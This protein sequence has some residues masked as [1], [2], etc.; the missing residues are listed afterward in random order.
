MPEQGLGGRLVSTQEQFLKL[1]IEA[2]KTAL[3]RIKAW[4]KC[5]SVDRNVRRFF[6]DRFNEM[7]ETP[8][9]TRNRAQIP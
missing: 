2:R 7:L 6:K 1:M 5:S 4:V 3:E 8:Y 9:R